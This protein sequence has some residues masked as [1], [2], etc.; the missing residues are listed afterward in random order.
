MM[1]VEGI[2]KLAHIISDIVFGLME[3][4]HYHNNLHTIMFKCNLYILLDMY[5][6]YINA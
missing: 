5:I 1:Y 4:K 6:V 3:V 2:A